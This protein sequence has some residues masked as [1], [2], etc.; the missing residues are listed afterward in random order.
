MVLVEAMA[1]GLPV[2]ATDCRSGP[3]EI[4][5]DGV[6]GVLVPPEDTEALADAMARLMSDESK[7][8][9]LASRAVET[10]ERF[11]V[12]RIT[13][14]WEDLLWTVVQDHHSGKHI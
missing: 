12:D 9:R 1:C 6:D 10:N 4:I 2:I 11:G 7:R 14:M 8:K 3:R 5:R 13:G